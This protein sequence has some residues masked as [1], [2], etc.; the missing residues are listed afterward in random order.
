MP[1][2]SKKLTGHIG[3]G[4]C[5]RSS[6]TVHARVLKFH[7]WF[8]HRKIFDT[9][10]FSCQSYLPFWSYVLLN[11]MRMKSDAGFN[12]AY[13]RSTVRHRID[14][15]NVRNAKNASTLHAQTLVTTNS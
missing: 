2:T 7:V 6:R 1:P 10:S 9:H 11:K 3:F 5:I 14:S 8:P 12:V 13:A 15:L 4:L